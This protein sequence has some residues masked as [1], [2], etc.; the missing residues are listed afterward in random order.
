MQVEPHDPLDEP[1]QDPDAATP[2]GDD[3]ELTHI[4]PPLR[5]WQVLD[6]GTHAARPPFARQSNAGATDDDDLYRGQ[7]I[8]GEA[9]VIHEVDRD[10]EDPPAWSRAAQT[11]PA[12][13]SQ[14]IRE[15]LD[16]FVVARHTAAPSY[17]DAG[18]RR[19]IN[20]GSRRSGALGRTF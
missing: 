17:G 9:T 20:G 12:T 14:S 4:P 2:L 10:E 8:D 3:S 19:R 5:N 1:Q 13:Y 6:D 7:T 18:K 15:Q 11:L 16:E